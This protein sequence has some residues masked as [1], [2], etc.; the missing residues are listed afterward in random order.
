MAWRETKVEDQRK[1]FITLYL[2]KKACLSELCRHFDISRKCAY[3]W[4]ER[5]RNLGFEGLKDKSR[6][7]SIQANAT[8]QNLVSRIIA[9]K[10]EWSKWGPKK[11]CAHLKKVEP[12]IPWPSSTTIGNVFDKYGL[13]VKRKLRKRLA[14]RSEPLSNCNASND[15]WCIDFKGWSLTSDQFKCE[16]FTLIDG[17]SRFLLCCEQLYAN[18]GANVWAVFERL[19]RQYGLPLRVRSDNGPPFATTGPGRLSRLS[20]KLLKAG[21]APE[22]IDPG[23]PEQ[24]GR[25]ERMHL[26]L[27][28]EGIDTTFSI[29]KQKEH[30]P[31]FVNYYNF[32]RPH[33][34]L[35]QRCP[36]DI[37]QRSSRC[38]NG[39]LR[40]P[41]YSTDY[42]IINVQ[43]C[44]K[45]RWKGKVVYVGRTFEG[46]PIGI[47]EEDDGYKAYYGQILL[48]KVEEDQIIYERRKPRKR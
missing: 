40:S 35:Q 16:P 37:Y 9:L 34:A 48:G 30:F 23:S 27:K 45:A 31:T 20:I 46:E 7:P 1:Q 41:E 8:D 44:G 11:I 15:V 19:F 10:R 13:T 26:T 47:K 21:V 4:L 42:Q 36:G 17:H 3:K 2:E 12:N 29:K 33:E 6:A 5:F 28:E 32:I 24:N 22:W 38:W 43:S 39:L 18:D 25:Q 14:E